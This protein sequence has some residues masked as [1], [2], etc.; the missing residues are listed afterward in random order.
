[1]NFSEVGRG[2]ANILWEPRFFTQTITSRNT[3]K[4]LDND[5]GLFVHNRGRFSLSFMRDA[6][7]STA[8]VVSEIGQYLPIDHT[9]YQVDLYLPERTAWPLR[10]GEAHSEGSCHWDKNIID[11][12]LFSYGGKFDRVHIEEVKNSLAHETHHLVRHRKVGRDRRLFENLITEGLAIHFSNEVGGT[13]GLPP[14]Y[15]ER[16]LSS[17][18]IARL[19]LMARKEYLKT[20]SYKRW[21]TWGDYIDRIPGG[22]GYLIGYQIVKK[23]L[24]H[25]PSAKPSTLTCV[26]AQEFFNKNDLNS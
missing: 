18:E 16:V 2:A 20:Q 10:E 11:L 5:L 13:I 19:K 25:N 12:L 26:P 7:Y 21:F 14:K 1:M 8:A 23:F 15:L 4:Y 24:D 9:D 3:R 22:A 17:E 6:L